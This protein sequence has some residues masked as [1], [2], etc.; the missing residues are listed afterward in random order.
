LIRLFGR[1]HQED[2]CQA[3]SIPPEHKYAA[4]GGPTFKV[5]FQLL[6][7]ATSRPALEVLKLLDAAIFQLIVGNADAH[8]KNYSLLYGPD[9]TVL[10]PLYDLMCT[11]AYPDVAPKLAMK[12][13]GLATIEDLKMAPWTQFASDTGLGG[14]FVRRRTAELAAASINQ[15]HSVADSIVMQGFDAPELSRFANIVMQRAELWRRPFESE[16]AR[17]LLRAPSPGPRLV[18]Q[19]PRGRVEDARSLPRPAPL[20]GRLPQGLR[21]RPGSVCCRKLLERSYVKPTTHSAQSPDRQQ[22]NVRRT[23]RKADIDMAASIS[24]ACF[25]I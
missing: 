11:I 16:H 1:L 17:S 2:F 22:T 13:A 20:R 6:R 23:D 8:G 4:E 3:L 10:A 15:A 19:R 25:K 9:G 18:F 21:A 12:I 7:D 14:A 24:T 5:G